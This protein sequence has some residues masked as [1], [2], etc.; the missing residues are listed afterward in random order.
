MEDKVKKILELQE[1]GLS[2]DSIADKLG[3][4]RLDS[5]NRFMRKKGYVVVNDK[6]TLKELDAEEA[7]KSATGSKR[8]Q[9]IFISSRN[10]RFSFKELD[11]KITDD[12][13]GEFNKLTRKY[14]PSKLK[15]LAMMLIKICPDGEQKEEDKTNG[16]LKNVRTFF[17]VAFKNEFSKLNAFLEQ[18]NIPFDKTNFD[19]YAS[20]RFFVKN[21]EIF[22]E[23]LN[24]LTIE[25]LENLR[26]KLSFINPF[27]ENFQKALRDVDK[28]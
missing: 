4:N 15:V 9:E 12:I 24:K 7:K 6:F 22:N 20:I 13:F 14:P 25:E 2:R 11:F 3:Y 16:L 10:R 28:Q 5:L 21:D 8:N 27:T 23:Y 26:K 18:E 19:T 17:E 1:E